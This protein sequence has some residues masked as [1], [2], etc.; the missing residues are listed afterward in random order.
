MQEVLKLE[1]YTTAPPHPDTG[2]VLSTLVLTFCINSTEPELVMRRWIYWIF[3]HTA[4]S[5]IPA[6]GPCLEIP[7]VGALA[8]QV[9]D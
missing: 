9:F 3:G 5:E 7:Q 6:P 2:P 1:H 4:E 8:L